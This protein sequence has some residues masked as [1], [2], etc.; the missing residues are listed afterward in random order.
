MN[1]VRPSKVQCSDD[2]CSGDA[3]VTKPKKRTKASKQNVI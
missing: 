1:A 3:V 2:M